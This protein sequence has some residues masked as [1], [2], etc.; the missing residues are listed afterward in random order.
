MI[1]DAI[2]KNTL[3]ALA[4]L[5]PKLLLAENTTVP[6]TAPAARQ[7]LYE[8]AFEGYQPFQ[9][10]EL[11]SWRSTNEAIAKTDDTDAMGGMKKGVDTAP[12]A[13]QPNGASTAMR[14]MVGMKGRQSTEAAAAAPHAKAH[15]TKA[16]D[17][18]VKSKS[19][20]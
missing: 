13:A 9:E 19:V 17:S 14:P 2:A 20:K 6:A 15:D 18:T 8:S 1:F 5:A 10:T 16:T 4:L 11:K 12:A 7:S 3:A